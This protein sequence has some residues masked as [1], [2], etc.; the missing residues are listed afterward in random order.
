MP[1][2]KYKKS[3]EQKARERQA[4]ENRVINE[5]N[6]EVV[7]KFVEDEAVTTEEVKGYVM[8][9]GKHKGKTLWTIAQEDPKYLDW[10]TDFHDGLPGDAVRVI[11]T[12]PD[13][14]TRIDRAL[15]SSGGRR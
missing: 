4:E 8:P 9:C 15:A 11:V 10:A 1:K 5:K 3:A 12:H 7:R 6:A 14:S 13:V 2:T